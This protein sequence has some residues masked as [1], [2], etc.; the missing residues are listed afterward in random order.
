MQLAL[1]ELFSAPRRADANALL[2]AAPGRAFNFGVPA[3]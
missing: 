1:N 3:S 2:A